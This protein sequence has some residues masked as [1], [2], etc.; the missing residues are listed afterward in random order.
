MLLFLLLVSWKC[1]LLGEDG[2]FER[3]LCVCE[4]L[5]CQFLAPVPTV[6]IR[7]RGEHWGVSRCQSQWCERASPLYAAR[8]LRIAL[9]HF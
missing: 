3:F 1:K 7:I 4:F 6:P 5:G 2:N 9:H 8:R